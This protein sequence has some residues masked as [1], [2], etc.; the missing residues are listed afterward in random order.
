MKGL[1]DCDAA[2]GK[3]THVSIC[4]ARSWGENEDIEVIKVIMSE[5]PRF[6][7]DEAQ[8]RRESMTMCRDWGILILNKTEEAKKAARKHEERMQKLKSDA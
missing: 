5:C 2:A 1:V 3:F 7:A 4:M 8:A 6:Q